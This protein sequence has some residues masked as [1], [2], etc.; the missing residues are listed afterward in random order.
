MTTR[1]MILSAFLLA[2]GSTEAFASKEVKYIPKKS[3]YETLSVTKGGTYFDSL[4]N[5]PKVMNPILSSDANSTAIEF[6][7]W[8][9]LFTEDSENLNP[10][11]YLATTYTI[12]ADKKTYTFTLNKDAKWDDG[13]PVT[14]ADVKFTFDTQMD[15]KVDAAPLRAYW[16][17]TTLEVVDPLT[18]RFSVATPKFD[19]LRSLYLFQVIQ[20]KQFEGEADFNKA[21]GIM[22]PMGN[23]PYKLK[24]F[25]RD[26]KIELERK[27]DW[28]GNSLPHFKNR[29]NADTIVLNIITD[30]NL[31]YEKFVKGD[32]DVFTFEGPGLEIYKNRVLGVDKDKFGKSPTDGKN[33]WT[34]EVK[35]K[36]PRGYSYVGWNL[37]KPLFQSKKTRQALA[38]LANYEQIS[39]KVFYGFSY[40][41]T[42]PFGSLTMN[43]APELRKPGKM[44]TFDPKKALA[45]LKEDGWAD[46]DGDNLLDKVINGKKTPF[47]FELKYNSNNPARGKVA[48]ILKEN[49]KSAG[50]EISIRAM[51]WNAYLGDVDSRNFEA[52]ILAWTATP[53]PNPRQTWHTEAE[54]NQG[55]NFVSYSNPQVDALIEKANLEFDL[56]K[57]A[58]IL[59]EINR[60][61]YDD[62]P[63]MFLLEPRSMIAGFQKKVKSKIWAQTYDVGPPTDIYSFAP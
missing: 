63:Y 25:S 3:S 16:E 42:S 32:M 24:S 54:K 26:Q 61:I 20:K 7:V 45:L 6:F 15:P 39:E 34:T 18:F 43:A 12:S 60:I 17:G 57:R 56:A 46:T 27:K 30:T 44:M 49:F 41:S 50:I 1:T 51:E 36:A 37:K 40:Q 48:Q 2:L 9:R 14:T 10:L 11:P 35:N 28:W 19:T 47:K 23:G 58:K 29:F 53:Y 22:Q 38:H 52:L 31:N 59:H 13:T 21:K 8:A 5:N 33:I 4:S 62:Q 55:S